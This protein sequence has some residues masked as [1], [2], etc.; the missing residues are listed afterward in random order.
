MADITA[1]PSPDAE[2]ELKPL[3]TFQ[4]DPREGYTSELTSLEYVPA[5]GGFLVVT[6]SEDET[7][8]FHGNTLWFVA[9]GTMGRPARSPRSRW[10]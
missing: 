9:D 3:F 5:L 4:A 2:L 7:N 8:A 1:S 10:R 6:A